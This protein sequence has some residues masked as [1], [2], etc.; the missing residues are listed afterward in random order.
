MGSVVKEAVASLVFDATLDHTAL[1]ER[2][3]PG[4]FPFELPSSGPQE[5]RHADTMARL[6]Y[7]EPRTAAALYG[8]DNDATR[9]HRPGDGKVLGCDLEALEI[10]LRPF[11]PSDTAAFAIAHLRLPSADPINTLALLARNSSA[12]VRDRLNLGETRETVHVGRQRATTVAYVHLDAPASLADSAL[13]WSALNQWL[14]S[15]ASAT[16]LASGGPVAEVVPDAEDPHALDGLV[17]L[18]A[19]WRALV[20]RDGASFVGAGLDDAFLD[21]HAAVYVRSIYLD[22]ILLGLTQQRG[23]NEIANQLAQLDDRGD[24]H[25]R[26]LVLEDELTRFR[27]VLWWQH[28]TRSGP[29][30]ALL[31]AFQE[32]HRLPTLLDQIIAEFSEDARQLE[33]ASNTRVSSALGLITLV[34]VPLTLALTGD[35]IFSANG[36]LRLL[37]V[38]AFGLLIASGLLLFAPARELLEPLHSSRHRQRARARRRVN[39]H[40]PRGRRGG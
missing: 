35:P 32:Q 40:E 38:V 31:R 28:V 2:W 27:N 23:L 7:F 33:A 4:P 18:S 16:P 8:T 39:R 34:G 19:S 13:P 9:W 12:D 36:A 30:N 17:Y 21:H 29:G 24:R 5:A 1:E 26:V 6:S 3:I 22:A 15:L 25:A 37:C 11:S 10:L 20:L 14:W